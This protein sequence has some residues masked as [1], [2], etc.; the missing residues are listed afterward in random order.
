MVKTNPP[1]T[2]SALA[3]PPSA[4]PPATN[5]SVPFHSPCQSGERE[6]QICIHLKLGPQL[7]ESCTFYLIDFV[8]LGISLTYVLGLVINE[9]WL[10]VFAIIIMDAT[11]SGP[12]FLHL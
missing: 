1:A 5:T 10:S 8:T 7:I 2:L 3:S 11:F 4:P 6:N 12:W 9:W